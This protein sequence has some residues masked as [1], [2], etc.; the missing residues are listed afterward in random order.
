M[1]GILFSL[2]LG[3]MGLKLMHDLMT[4]EL[5]LKE[6]T[7]GGWRGYIREGP[8]NVEVHVSLKGDEVLFL[9]PDK[10]IPEEVCKK[11]VQR[12]AAKLYALVS[13]KEA[14]PDSVDIVGPA[15][16]FCYYC[17]EPVYMP[18]RCNRCGGYFCQDH[19]LPEQHDCPGDEEEKE[20]AAIKKPEE[21]K[22]KEEKEKRIIVRVIACG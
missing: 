2:I 10:S 17:L 20:G 15:N 21:P 5:G 18:Y 4:R 1:S 12:L 3:G 8:Y 11:V 22:E 9:L 16:S 19:R 14:P 13:Q 7:D 6:L